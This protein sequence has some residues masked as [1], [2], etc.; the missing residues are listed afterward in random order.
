MGWAEWCSGL[1][2]IALTPV[3][4]P[5]SGCC[6]RLR[7]NRGSVRAP[8]ELIYGKRMSLATGAHEAVPDAS[9]RTRL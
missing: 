9:A 2:F 8:C 7:I 3:Q 5:A 1:G 4:L 6:N